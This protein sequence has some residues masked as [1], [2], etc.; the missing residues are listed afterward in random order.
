MTDNYEI[1]NQASQYFM[2]GYNCSQS[3]FGALAN[4]IDLDTSTALKIA[5]PFGGGISQNGSVCGAVSG[6][7]MALGYHFGNDR[8]NRSSKYR[9]Y[10]IGSQ[11]L[12]EFTERFGDVICPKLLGLDI[13]KPDE[14]QQ[15]RDQD[16]FHSLCSQFVIGAV[17]IAVKI[18]DA[19]EK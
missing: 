8:P 19:K 14:L 13:R 17:E 15:A 4:K 3:S 5:A 10:E 6:A 16:L 7:L 11:F 2:A 12:Q 1:T 18:I 9:N